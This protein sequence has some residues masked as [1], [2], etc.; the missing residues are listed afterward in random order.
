MG[1]REF[2]MTKEIYIDQNDYTDDPPPKYKR[3]TVGKEVRLRNSYVIKC[4]QVIKDEKG[5]PIELRCSYDENTLGKKPE[6]RK[7]QGVIHWVSAKYSHLAQ[8][9]EYDRLFTVEHPDSNKQQGDF[10]D[11]FNKNSCIVYQH[12]RVEPSLARVS[13]GDSFQFEREGYYVADKESRAEELIFN[14]TVTLRDSWAKQEKP[15][16]RRR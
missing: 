16:R 12:A 1:R 9:R 2:K 14:Q 5:Q 11:Y 7:V 3:L 8:I 6:G 13:A 10:L 15:R 4:E